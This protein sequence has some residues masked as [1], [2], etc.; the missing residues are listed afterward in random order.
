MTIEHEQQE[1]F[2][3]EAKDLE[4]KLKS[5]EMEIVRTYIN[6]INKSGYVQATTVSKTVII[7]DV[8]GS[9]RVL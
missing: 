3:E 7:V 1:L 8:T 5:A 9:A 6:K 2:L 4:E